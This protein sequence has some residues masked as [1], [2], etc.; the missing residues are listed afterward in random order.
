MTNSPIHLHGHEF[1]ITGTDGGLTNKGFRTPEVTADIAV[2][3]MRQIEVKA[4]E[5]GDWAFHCHNSHH[6]TNAMGHDVPTMIG[7][8]HIGMAKRIGNLI[9][10]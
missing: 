2:G 9:P 6:T 4:D 10:D 3:Q 7:V 1:Y 8:D 5:E